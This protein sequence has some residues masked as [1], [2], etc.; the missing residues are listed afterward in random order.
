MTS[1]GRRQAEI[2]HQDGASCGSPVPLDAHQQLAKRPV[3]VVIGGSDDG[4]GQEL[5]GHSAVFYSRLVS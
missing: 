2:E 5:G 4:A 3:I 1:I